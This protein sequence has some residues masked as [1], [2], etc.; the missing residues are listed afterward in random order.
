MG[1]LCTLEPKHSL[2]NSKRARVGIS[3]SLITFC[4][5][6]CQ[7]SLT[8]PI[9]NTSAQLKPC[10]CRDREEGLTLFP[11][12]SH[13]VCP[14]LTVARPA[15]HPTHPPS[16]F[17]TFPPSQTHHATGQGAPNPTPNDHGTPRHQGPLSPV[18]PFTQT[19]PIPI[20]TLRIFSSSS[21]HHLPAFLPAAP[22][23]TPQLV[24]ERHVL[25]P[26]VKHMFGYGPLHTTPLI[27]KKP[28][29]V[30]VCVCV[31]VQMYIHM[32]M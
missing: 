12:S 2:L 19:H 24:K 18:L 23:P 17:P 28:A 21:K 25:R 5:P 27:E 22:T 14:S 26:P 8:C 32:Y 7:S 16:H 13:F 30:C 10:T 20:C 11:P 31:C 6:L 1:A 9:T 29:E 3:H 4:A 15:H